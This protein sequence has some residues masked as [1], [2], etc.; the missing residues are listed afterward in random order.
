ML[1]G[2]D[3]VYVCGR[4]FDD[5]R[6]LAAHRRQVTGHD[7]LG[8]HLDEHLGSDEQDGQVIELPQHRYHVGDE[9]DGEQGIEN[10]RKGQDFQIDGNFPILDQLKHQ[11]HLLPQFAQKTDV[12]QF[13]IAGFLFI[14]HVTQPSRQ[15]D[16]AFCRIIRDSPR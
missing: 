2:R 8:S 3:Y 12:F 7:L 10:A 4:P 15:W 16:F 9:V 14:S 5:V 11:A 6:C 1:H 13:V